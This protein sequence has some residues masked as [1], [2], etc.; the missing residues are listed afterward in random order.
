MA[1][2]PAASP[3]RARPAK[4][5]LPRGARER[6]G[7]V[8]ERLKEEYPSAHT[9]LTWNDPFQ[10]LVA[11]ILS[12]QTTDVQVNSVMPAL[13][14]KYPD[15]AALAG[16]A[17]EDVELIVK[18]TGFFHV[19]AQSIREMAQDVIRLHAGA[20]PDTLEELVKLHGV[21]RKTANVVLGV[22]FGKPGFAVDTHVTRL[23]Q[24]LGLT[25]SPDPVKI[26]TDVTSIVPA[27]EWTSLSLRLILH[28]RRVCAARK[29]LCEKCVLN[30]IC[31]CAF[32]WL[33]PKKPGGC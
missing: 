7:I 31:P 4:R 27:S 3:K 23:T 22:A 28:G 29:P 6:A 24:R 1:K 8:V 32:F 16:A 5:R 11:V 33:K 17:Q 15:A 14:A 2:K 30:D 13:V 10:L 21:G 18:P 26:E 25:G 12:A 9:E 19:K 20:V